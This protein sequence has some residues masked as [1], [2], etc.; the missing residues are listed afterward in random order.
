MAGYQL[1]VRG[2]IMRGRFRYSF[3]KPVPFTPGRVEKVAYTMPDVCHTFKPGHRIVVQIQS[4]WF[5]LADRNPQTFVPSIYEAKA[6]DFKKSTIQIHRS[7]K[8]PSG[9]EVLVWK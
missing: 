2:E 5:P 4:S 1:M 7:A 3:K 8:F 9:L 6:S